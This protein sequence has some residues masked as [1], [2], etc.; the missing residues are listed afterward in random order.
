MREIDE[1]MVKIHRNQTEEEARSRGASPEEVGYLEITAIPTKIHARAKEEK[2][3]S[4]PT[5]IE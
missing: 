3:R 2:K 5:R 4:V 1:Q